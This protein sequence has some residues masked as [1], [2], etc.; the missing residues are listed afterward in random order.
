MLHLYL[1]LLPVL[2]HAGCHVGA[3]TC[4]VDT[5]TRILGAATV[6]HDDLSLEYCAQLCANQNYTLAG[7]EFGLQ[8]YCGHG[9]NVAAPQKG[10]GCTTTCPGNSKQSC[11]GYWFISVFAVNCSGA[12]EPPPKEPPL[13]V[14]P[15]VDRSSKYATMP[16][17]NA[18]LPVDERVAD[19]VSRMTL[20][21]KIGA[22]GTSSPAIPSLGLLS[23]NWWSEASSGVGSGRNT[24]TTKF[25]FPITTGMSFNRTLWKL[26][27][28]Q[29]GREARA[30]MNTGNGYSTFWAP[31]V[32]LA[33]E[34]RW[35]RNIE[36]PG[37]DPYVTAEYAEHFVKGFQEAPEDPYHVQASA[38]CKHY[39]AN[40][41]ESTTQPDGE[42]QDRHHVDTMVSMRD[43]VDSYM[44]PFQACVEKGRVTSLMCS[45][46]AV[47]GVPSC[48]NGWLLDTVAR[49][50]W[51]FDGYIA[52]DCD[53]D[54]DVFASHHYTATAE[55]AVRDVLRAGT[56]VDCTSFVPKHAQSALDKGLITEEDIDARLKM[57]FRMRMRLSHFD[58]VGP[59]DAIPASTI[60]SDYA[61]ELSHDGARQSAT[62]V[63][64]LNSTLPLD[65]NI[66]GTVAVIG[67]NSQLSKSDSG[68]Y[69]P[70]DVCGSNFWTLVD[71]VAQG[72]KVKTTSAPG[73]PGVTSENRSGIPA[74]VKL[75][76]DADMVVLGVG[77]DLSWAAEGH[78]ATNISFT[79]AQSALIDQVAAAAKKPVVVVVL[80][81]TPLDIS[82]LLANPKVGAVLHLGQPSVTVLGVS[83][84]L[85]GDR[86]PAGRTIQTVYESSYQYQISI[87]DFGM[88]PGP[89]PYAR[90]DCSNHDV[91]QCPKGTNPGRTY[92][93][94]TGKAVVPFGFGLSY[95]TFVYAVVSQ[96]SFVSLDP[97][98]SLLADAEA[99]GHAFVSNKPAEQAMQTELWRSKVQFAVNVTNTGSKDADDVILG[100]LTPPGAG[101]NGVP[102]KQLFGF[103]RVHVK[104]GETVTV[105][106]YPAITDFAQAG[107]DGKLRAFPGEYRVHF[108]V[109][110]TQE[111]GMG[112]VEAD[113]FVASDA[114]VYV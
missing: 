91:S 55:E 85:Y 103:D 5:P 22:L 46:N 57:L 54:E 71:A 111:H 4:Y 93:F 17:C 35:G 31:V 100:F 23:Y 6:V 107:L 38:C 78:D 10:N 88:R 70:S 33:R 9:F 84:V 77:T 7:A 113:A 80:T 36:T 86:S 18:T 104:A 83:E 94:Y 90:P 73:V 15:C 110:E 112:Y 52:S 95:T 89:S 51:G 61:I 69:G 53:A 58:P 20:A 49:K 67:P 39:V 114:A 82:S 105:L 62:L 44:R 16:F 12:P 34:P 60:C 42:H 75:A 30:M 28:R 2:A 27:G 32:N 98:V 14:N 102:L 13:M 59:L 66:V 109:V 50:N 64:N 101:Q 19:A 96:P 76:K 106:L 108:G 41:L 87:F 56:D 21:E 45:Y 72:G 8:C 3:T 37:E 40:E 68:Y 43:L 65:R 99:A 47:N 11:G 24:Q 81:A 74:A 26:V 79:D 25:P 63:K 48:A 97:L 92:R 1:F 29:I